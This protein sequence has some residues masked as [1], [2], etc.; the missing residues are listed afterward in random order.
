MLL[1]HSPLLGPATW[2]R[3]E[4]WLRKQGHEAQ[5]VDLGPEPRTPDRVLTTVAAAAAA[6]GEPVVLVPHSNAGLY[7]PHLATL[8][9]VRATVYVDAALP[10][11]AAEGMDTAL[12]APAFL[13][14]LRTLVDPNGILI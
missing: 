4:V 10:D 1:V 2:R 12:A 9:D 6:V 8:V 11:P 13:G 14:F 5:A 3:V 7:A